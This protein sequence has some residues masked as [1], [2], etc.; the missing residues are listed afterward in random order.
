ME[1]IFE[2]F[3]QIIFEFLM[4]AGLESVRSAFGKGKKRSSVSAYFGIAIMGFIV[5]MIISLCFPE[6]IVKKP[7]L[8][9]LGFVVSPLIVGAMMDAF[10]R[11]R[12]KKG[13][14]I[15]RLATFSGGAL[16]AFCSAL[17]RWL[18]IESTAG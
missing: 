11:W 6:R 10:G 2:F 8:K 4:E 16:F 15:S 18:I 12:K 13:H 9:G 17:A 14:K 1:I 3:L 7:P 5:G